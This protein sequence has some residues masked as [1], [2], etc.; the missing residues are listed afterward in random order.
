MTDFRKDQSYREFVKQIGD[1]DL[2]KQLLVEMT[3][4]Q[5]KGIDFEKITIVKRLIHARDTSSIKSIFDQS[6][7]STRIGIE[8]LLGQAKLTIKGIN[9]YQL[10]T[11]ESFDFNN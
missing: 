8:R 7:Q 5:R 10:D 9:D 6:N 1:E 11:D 4:E 3:E 2:A